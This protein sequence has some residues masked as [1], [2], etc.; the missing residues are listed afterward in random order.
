[1]SRRHHPRSTRELALALRAQGV[2][3]REV[4]T[5]LGIGEST[6]LRWMR[7]A[8]AG[9]T[10]RRKRGRPLALAPLL[11]DAVRAIVLATPTASLTDIAARLNAD[12]GTR[13]SRTTLW[14]TLRRLGLR[15]D[16]GAWRADPAEPA[17][18]AQ[19]DPA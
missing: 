4:I 10:I 8:R 17:T 14:R 3:Q 12:T 16:E 1:M 15:W 18:S 19:P 2:R 9:E 13:A 5:T 6:L 11:C 7:S